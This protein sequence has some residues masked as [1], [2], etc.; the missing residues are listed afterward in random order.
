MVTLYGISDLGR[1]MPNPRICRE[2]WVDREVRAPTAAELAAASPIT[3]VKAGAPP[4]L[5][6]HG[7]KDEAVPF[8]QSVNVDGGSPGSGR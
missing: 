7:D 1:T 2:V 4:F 3:H 5:L 8:A 6:I